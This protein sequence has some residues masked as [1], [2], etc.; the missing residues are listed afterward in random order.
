MLGISIDKSKGFLFCT[1]NLSGILRHQ[2]D[3][4]RHEV[5]AIDANRLLNTAPDDLKNYLV[6]KYLIEPISL[7]RDKWYAE[8]REMQVDVRHDRNR[9]IDDKR[10]PVMMPGERVEV[11]IPF[12]GDGEL[13]YAE[14]N[15]STTSPPRA[16][17][18]SNELVLRYDSP[19]D[20]PREVRP[21][22]DRAIQEIEQYLEWQRGMIET[23]NN[24]LRCLSL[25]GSPAKP[26]QG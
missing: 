25:R 19:A 22:V 5:D 16:T 7:L 6:S 3:A 12:E 20:S 26:G 15:T 13:F 4:L 21:L 17:I 11:R 9:W 10:L 24:G 23:H 14:P 18:D 2:A 8:T 1:N